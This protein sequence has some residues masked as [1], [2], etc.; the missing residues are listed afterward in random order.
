VASL[1]ASSG[2]SDISPTQFADW[3]SLTAAQTQSGIALGVCIKET[4]MGSGSWSEINRTDPI[5]AADITSTTLLGS[6]NKMIRWMRW[7]HT[8]N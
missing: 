1:K 3:N 8:E 2:I 7:R 5:Y 6:L 4:S